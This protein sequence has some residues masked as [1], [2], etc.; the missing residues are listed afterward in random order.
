MESTER[1][2][3]V[4]Q[5]VPPEKLDSWRDTFR[6][7]DIDGDGFVS[8]VDLAKV[9]LVPLEVAETIEESMHH[10]TPLHGGNF[11]EGDFLVSMAGAH[12]MRVPDTELSLEATRIY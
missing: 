5:E 8:A 6:Q 1:P 2:S 3:A 9:G 12:S 4:V 7:L 10:F 11:S